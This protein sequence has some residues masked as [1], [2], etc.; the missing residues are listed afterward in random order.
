MRRVAAVVVLAAAFAP[1]ANAAAPLAVRATLDE[2]DVQFGETVGTHVVVLVDPSRVRPDTVRIVQDPGPLTV[3][4]QSGGTHSAGP[5]TLA[6]SADR[7]VA[8]LSP[9][10]LAARG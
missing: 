5:R 3:L 10:C 6:V 9:A 2:P 1:A 7:V 4:S 8:C